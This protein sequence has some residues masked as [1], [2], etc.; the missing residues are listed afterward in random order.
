MAEYENY[1][2]NY[3]D[4]SIEANN[5]FEDYQSDFALDTAE[6]Q[7]KAYEPNLIFGGP[8]PDPDAVFELPEVHSP[9]LV[10][11]LLQFD[12]KELCGEGDIPAHVL[13]AKAAEI[14]AWKVKANHPRYL[15][16]RWVELTVSS[17]AYAH[18]RLLNSRTHIHLRPLCLEQLFSAVDSLKTEF[19]AYKTP[20]HRLASL[21]Q[22]YDRLMEEHEG[23]LPLHELFLS[24][25][26]RKPRYRREEFAID[27][28]RF[29]KN[30]HL[31]GRPVQLHQDPQ[32]PKKDGYLIWVGKKLKRYHSIELAAQTELQS[33]N[34]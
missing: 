33:L 29:I 26:R 4:T 17:T 10:D 7:A 6:N 30:G 22:A 18:C 25:Q 31:D 24:L 12:A 9:S 20:P 28:F 34:I 32:A 8:R 3:G 2:D 27:L 13:I 15:I 21:T 14:K 16:N 23:T 5:D 1:E 11:A 19:L